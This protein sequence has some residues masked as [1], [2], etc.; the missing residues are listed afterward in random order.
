MTRAMLPAYLMDP[1]AWAHFIK[2]VIA[3]GVAAFG[4]AWFAFLFQRRRETKRE[5]DERYGAI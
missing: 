1:K 2:D 4:G 5:N 3:P